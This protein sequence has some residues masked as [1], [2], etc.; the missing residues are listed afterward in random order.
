MP[1]DGVRLLQGNLPLI[2]ITIIITIIIQFI[3]CLNMAKV[4]TKRTPY[5][6]IIPNG[7]IADELWSYISLVSSELYMKS[8]MVWCSEVDGCK[9]V[10]GTDNDSKRVRSSAAGQCHWKCAP[11]CA[12]YFFVPPEQQRTSTHTT[13]NTHP[14]H[15]HGHGHGQFPTFTFCSVLGRSSTQ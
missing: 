1:G 4:T 15:G 13:L 6:F 11:F 12:V 14:G 3:R 10:R 7:T 5:V 2:I 9:Y 8:A